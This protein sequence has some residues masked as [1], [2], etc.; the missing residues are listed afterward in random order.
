VTWAKAPS[1][2][3]CKPVAG[4]NVELRTWLVVRAEAA[5]PASVHAVHLHKPER[6]TGA[7][8]A[9]A[10]DKIQEAGAGHEPTFAQ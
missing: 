10:T 3:G 6:E 5:H 9:A 2:P 8:A 1:S 7:P 4:D